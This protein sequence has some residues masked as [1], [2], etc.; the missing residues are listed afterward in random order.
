MKPAAS[1]ADRVPHSGPGAADARRE[2][3]LGCVT[4]AIA[5]GYYLLAIQI[6]QSDI[7]D[8]IGPQGLPKTYAALLAALSIMLIGRA[9]AARRA[10]RYEPAIEV[11]WSQP[12]RI[13][14]RVAAMLLIGVVYIA[15]VPWLGYLLS[16]AALIA[17]T[18]YVQ[19]GFLNRASLVVAIGGALV[20]W[21]LFVQLLHIAHPP[22]IWPS[23]L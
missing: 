12:R 16:I 22:G 18:I 3:T 4:L 7:T 5:I 9:I 20:F 8:V 21:V 23:L 11:A 6:P 15:V 1:N 17:S 2:L 13:E 14:W 10:A 19:R